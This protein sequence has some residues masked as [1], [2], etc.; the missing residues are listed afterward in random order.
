MKNAVVFIS[1]FLM[2]ANIFGQSNFETAIKSALTEFDSSKTLDDLKAVAAKFERISAA[3]TSQWLPRYYSAY[4]YCLL[5]FKTQDPAIIKT[6]TDY[7]QKQ[8]DEAIKLAPAESEVLT[9]QGMIYQA[10]VMIDPMNYG[11]EYSGK[12]AGAFEAAIKLNP[13]NPRP[14]YLQGMNLFYTPEQYGGGKKVAVGLLSKAAE[15]YTA[16]VPAS[17]ISPDWGSEHCNQMLA[18]C[19]E[20]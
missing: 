1:I 10:V 12:A 8:V 11:R 16:F 13:A 5:S 14:Y 2:T 20:N 15:L 17:D 19:K 3:E 9:L 18:S 6:Y 7:A 4:I